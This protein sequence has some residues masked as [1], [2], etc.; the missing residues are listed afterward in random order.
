LQH[1]AGGIARGDV[2]QRAPASNVGPAEVPRDHGGAV[3]FLHHG[4]VDRFLRRAHEGF[5][6]QPQEAEI[7]AGAGN[8][9][10]D[11]GRDIRRQPPTSTG[12]T[13]TSFWLP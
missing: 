3:G 11:G 5:G 1:V 6:L 7:V 10:L 8:C 12:R 13:G 2:K 9:H 4:I